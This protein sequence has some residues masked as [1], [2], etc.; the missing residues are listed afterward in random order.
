MNWA[1]DQGLTFYWGTSEW[2]H[3][4]IAEAWSIA[5]RLGLVGP[6]VEQVRKQLVPRLNMRWG[7]CVCLPDRQVTE[8]HAPHFTIAARVQPFPSQTRGGE[9]PQ[10]KH[11]VASGTGACSG[12]PCLRRKPASGLHS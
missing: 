5:D 3:D 1:I 10:H 4:Q 9:L 11:N 12:T 6:C 8:R 7:C 2:S